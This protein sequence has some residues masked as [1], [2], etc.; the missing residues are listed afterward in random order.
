MWNLYKSDEA[1]DRAI[2]AQTAAEREGLD[3]KGKRLHDFCETRHQKRAAERQVIRDAGHWVK[4]HVVG[5]CHAE[6]A[7]NEE[8]R[9][10]QDGVTNNSVIEQSNVQSQSQPVEP[11]SQSQ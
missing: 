2:L 1:E 6:E 9:N 8:N 11:Q 10:S 3:W 4:D 7:T 5:A